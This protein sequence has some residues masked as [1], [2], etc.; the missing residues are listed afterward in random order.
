MG[1]FDGIPLDADPAPAPAVKQLPACIMTIKRASTGTEILLCSVSPPPVS[2]RDE[3]KRR[4]LPLFTL[5]EIPAMRRIDPQAL[6]TLITAR[7]LMGWGGSIT[8]TEAA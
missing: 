5:D 8:Y 1:L 3:A 6:D 2:A 4:K 7:L